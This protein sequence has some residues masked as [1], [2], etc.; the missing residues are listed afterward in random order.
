[1]K[2]RTP[3]F[4]AYMATWRNDVRLSYKE[5]AAIF[6][7]APGSI[8]R[9]VHPDGTLPPPDSTT[10]RTR[11]APGRVIRHKDAQWSLGLIRNYVR[12]LKNEDKDEAGSETIVAESATPAR[13]ER[14][15]EEGD[16]HGGVVV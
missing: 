6:C 10:L 14:E 11:G 12:K 3:V 15:E 7:V 5:V 2:R 16:L 8:S 13:K 1:M 4:P 9:M